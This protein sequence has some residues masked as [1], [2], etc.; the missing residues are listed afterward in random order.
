MLADAARA[1]AFF[2]DTRP[3]GLASLRLRP[4]SVLAPSAL[5]FRL[6]EGIE[7]SLAGPQSSHPYNRQY[8]VSRPAD[9]LHTAVMPMG[10]PVSTLLETNPNETIHDEPKRS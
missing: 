6:H 8:H 2:D 7:P 1:P 9:R 5:R 4:L 10:N 3:N